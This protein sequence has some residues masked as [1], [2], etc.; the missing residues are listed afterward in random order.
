MLSACIITTTLY[1]PRSLASSTSTISTSRILGERLMT[2]CTVRSR[3]LQASLWNTM[4]MLV[5]GRSSG[6]TLVLQLST[7]SGRKKVERLRVST[8]STMIFNSDKS[9][10][11]GDEWQMSWNTGKTEPDE[12]S[13]SEAE[14]CRWLRFKWSHLSNR[15]L[16]VQRFILTGLD[17]RTRPRD[18]F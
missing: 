11:D 5:L 2:L 15:A 7:E 16:S 10:V 17:D 8:S 9:V 4:T 13:T 18:S 1:R 12:K 6:Y 3:V 14:Y